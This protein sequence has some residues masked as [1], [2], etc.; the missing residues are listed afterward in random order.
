MTSIFTPIRGLD[1][2]RSKVI[3]AS[4]RTRANARQLRSPS[5]SPNIFVFG[6]NA[7]AI[8]ASPASKSVVN[9]RNIATSERML[10]REEKYCECRVLIKARS[11]SRTATPSHRHLPE[12]IPSLRHA[13]ALLPVPRLRKSLCSR[14]SGRDF[15]RAPP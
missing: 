10:A 5:D 1:H 11:D 13:Y 7:A 14:Y 3:A 4:F 15:R 2:A 8:C 6:H 9:P 12:A